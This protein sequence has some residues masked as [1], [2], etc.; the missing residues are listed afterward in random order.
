MPYG[1]CCDILA[2]TRVG[3]TRKERRLIFL[4]DLTDRGPDSPGVVALVQTLVVSGLAQCV[5]GNHDLNILLGRTKH[6]NSWYFGKE[7]SEDGFL[8][9]QAL[10][11]QGIRERVRNFFAT[12]PLAL[13]REDARVV[14]AC[15]HPPMIELARAAACAVDLY[16]RFRSQIQEDHKSRPNLDQCDRDL[17]YQNRNP[18]KVLTSGLEKRAAEMHRFGGRVRCEERV[19]WWENYCDPQICIF[20]HYATTLG[21]QHGHGSAYCIDFSV[22]YRWTER[23]NG[24]PPFKTKLAACRLP[25][26]VMVLDDGKTENL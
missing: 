8:V 5:L 15:W 26:M 10:A 3:H 25:E 16:E 6:D 1:S 24:G 23:R 7:F 12:L 21:Q 19:R 18:V 9:P 20:G 2:T 14:H 4:G 11:D 13:E 22:G 17:D